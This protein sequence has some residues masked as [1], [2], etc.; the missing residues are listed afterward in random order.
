MIHMRDIRAESAPDRLAE[1]PGS[2]DDEQ[3]TALRIKPAP[4][5]IIKQSLHGRGV[6]SRA[7]D[8]DW[9]ALTP[10]R[11]NADGPDHQLTVTQV[12]PVDLNRDEIKFRWIGSHP[13][14]KLR[15]RQRLEP[16]GHG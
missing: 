12:Q 14:I 15:L 8:D 13:F 7:L 16:A 4:D 9:G 10:G 2:V 3:I 11:V 5:Q 1:R 6:L